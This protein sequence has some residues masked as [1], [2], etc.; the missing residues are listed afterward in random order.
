MSNEQ[1]KAAST[2]S[3]GSKIFS[4]L[5]AVAIIG[6]GVYCFMQMSAWESGGGDT[7]RLPRIVI[8][9]IE[10]AE[11]VIA[12][13]GKWIVSGLLTLAGCLLGYNALFG[14]EEEDTEQSTEKE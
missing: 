3:W 13:S 1:N 11:G 9:V 5:I 14:S 4:L 8:V 2:G 6:Y 7:I 10:I 12:G